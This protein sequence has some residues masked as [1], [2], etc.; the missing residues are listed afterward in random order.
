MDQKPGT[1]S[2]LGEKMQA[3][4]NRVPISPAAV[5]RCVH[6]EFRSVTTLPHATARAYP[7]SR[8]PGSLPAPGLRLAG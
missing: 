6:D 3:A 4:L 8:H 2:D 5:R 1:A 7:A